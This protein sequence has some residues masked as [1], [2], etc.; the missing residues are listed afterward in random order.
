MNAKQKEDEKKQAFGVSHN[1]FDVS[2]YG[3]VHMRNV[4]AA[5]KN[6][7]PTQGYYKDDKENYD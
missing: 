7:P 4:I 2:S 3:E 5:S 1:I 6:E